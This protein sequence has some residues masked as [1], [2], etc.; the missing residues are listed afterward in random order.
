DT[1][2]YSF[3]RNDGDPVRARADLDEAIAIL[4]AQP[5]VEQALGEATA[6]MQRH[7]TDDAF[8]RQVALVREKQALEL[9]LANLVQSNEDA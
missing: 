6:A 8:E 4:V 3:T 7:F 1:M 5:E 2:P 9:R